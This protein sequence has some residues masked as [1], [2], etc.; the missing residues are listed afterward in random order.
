MAAL[1]SPLPPHAGSIYTESAIAGV[2][3]LQVSSFAVLDKVPS[4]A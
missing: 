2:M 4:D 1:L 3:C